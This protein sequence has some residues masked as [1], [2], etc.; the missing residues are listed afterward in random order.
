LNKGITTNK[1][2]LRNFCK[3]LYIYEKCFHVQ[4][5]LNEG[6]S[7]G[8]NHCRNRRLL[9][10]KYIF[11]DPIVDKKI[12][13]I[14]RGDLLD[15]RDRLSSKK[16]GENTINKILGIL[17]TAFNEAALRE[18]IHRNPTFLIGNLKYQQK[19]IGVFTIEEIKKLFPKDSL[20]PWTSLFDY[21]LFFLAC[22]TGMRRGEILALQWGDI[23]FQKKFL[24]VQRAWKGDNEKGKPKWNRIR[25]V[26]LPPMLIHKLLE[27]KL[28]QIENN[29]STQF[30]ID[31]CLVFCYPNGK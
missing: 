2:T 8:R 30:S 10:E 29:Y 1:D 9:I 23:D 21:T 31:D 20:G 17:K 5:L 25:Y 15:F 26:A 19:E 4:R 13:N 16:I 24:I 3:D 7:I 22:M 27:L 11:T 18:I 12:A 28:E 14:N 6:K